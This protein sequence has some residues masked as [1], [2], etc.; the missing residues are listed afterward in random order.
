M[1]ELYDI[2][3]DYIK[4]LKKYKGKEI[5]V[6]TLEI[7][8]TLAHTIKNLCKVIEECEKESYG[9][10][11]SMN[12]GANNYN[13]NYGNNYG[14]VPEMYGAQGRGPG[15]AR[16]SMGRYAAGND[17]MSELNSLAMSMPDEQSRQAVQSIMNKYR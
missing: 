16:D 1:Q 3:D 5:T 11:M 17:M 10:H 14:Y 8:D 12:Y 13:A 7:V 15:A 9:R 4:E 6:Q 2:K